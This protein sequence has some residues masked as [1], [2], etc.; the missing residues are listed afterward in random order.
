MTVVPVMPGWLGGMAVGGW[1]RHV[2]CCNAIVH[3]LQSVSSRMRACERGALRRANAN[4][5]YFIYLLHSYIRRGV[6]HASCMPMK[7]PIEV[8]LIA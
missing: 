7:I 1:L 3:D 2:K 8:S 5:L 4:G 6:L